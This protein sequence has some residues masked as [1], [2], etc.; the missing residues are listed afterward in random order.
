MRTLKTTVQNSIN[1]QK[2]GKLKAWMA[3]PKVAGLGG[4]EEGGGLYKRRCWS[5]HRHHPLLSYHGVCS[6][7]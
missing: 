5:M 6:A 7:S 3:I 4:R 1:R 2:G